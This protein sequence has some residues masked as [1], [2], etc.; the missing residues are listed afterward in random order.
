TWGG[1]RV[2]AEFTV[3]EATVADAAV[4]ARHRAEMFRDMGRLPPPLYP[5]LMSAGSRYLA[6]ALATG[7][8]AGWVGAPGDTPGRVAAGAG[9]RRRRVRP[10]PT[11]GADGVVLAEGRQ[12]IVLNVFTERP[13]RRRGLARLLMEHVLVAARRR[14]LDSLVLHAS[15]EGRALYEQLGF[16]AT[17]EMRYG[18]PLG[19]AAS[20]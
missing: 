5:V 6:D 15:D 12:G 10:H 2:N 3:R 9:L 19:R 16:V 17:N 14:G 11:G 13:W 7:E 4:I 8:D 18:G 1:R 20:P